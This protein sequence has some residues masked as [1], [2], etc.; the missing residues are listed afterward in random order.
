[1]SVLV[2]SACGG[3]DASGSI[4]GGSDAALSV[5]DFTL[6]VAEF[7]DQLDEW[8]KLFPGEQTAGTGEGT[9]AMTFVSGRASVNVQFE[10]LIDALATAG[11]E[12]TAEH[13]SAA[14][15]DTEEQLEQVKTQVEAGGAE[16]VA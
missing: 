5:N 13:L 4:G 14:Q 3:D 8:A 1:M 15:L 2:L 16:Y 10:A 11:I 6:T 7:N 9:Y 12:V